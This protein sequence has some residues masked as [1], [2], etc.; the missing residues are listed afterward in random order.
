MSDANDRPPQPRPLLL[1]R[2]WVIALLKRIGLSTRAD[3]SFMALVPIVGILTG[4]VSILLT[5]LMTL[6]QGLFWGAEHYGVLDVALNA[7]WRLCVLAPAAG[8]IAIGLITYLARQPVRGTGTGQLIEAVALHGGYVATAKSLLTQLVAVFTVGS[9]GSAGREGPLMVAGA[10]IGSKLGRARGL[11]GN[12]LKL[13]VGCGIASGIAA[14]YNAP[15][16]GALFAMEVV[17]GNFALNTFAPIVIASVLGTLLSREFLFLGRDR[18]YDL[19]PIAQVH[20]QELLLFAV[21]GIFAGFLAVLFISS[22]EWGDIAFERI[23]V[24]PH[25]KP[26]IGFT[27]L[28]L[29]G[30]AF[31]YIYGNGFE[32]VDIAL[33][34]DALARLGLFLLIALPLVKL[35]ATALTM[36]SGGTGGLFTPSLFVGALVG[37]AFGVGAIAVIPSWASGAHVYALVGMGAIAAATTH[38]PLS[39]ILIIYELTGQYSL[40]LPL[41]AACIVSN[42]ISR[43]LKQHGVFTS[44]MA[45]RGV[46]LPHRLEELVLETMTARD[47]VRE[48]PLCLRPTT[49]VPDIFDRFMETRRNHLYVVD[50]AKNF[51]GA[52]AL[53]DLKHVLQQSEQM[54]F[55]LALDVM[56]PD[57]PY[58]ALD[59]R[60]TQVAQTFA[61]YDHERLPVVESRDSRRFAGVISKRDIMSVYTSE[62][63]Q[64]PSLLAKFTNDPGDGGEKTFV[65]LPPRYRVDQVMV[66]DD[67]ADM[68][69]AEL[70]FPANYL[71]HVLELKRT[72][73]QGEVTRHIPDGTSVLRRGD[74]IVV[75]GPIEHLTRLKEI[76][77]EAE[78]ADGN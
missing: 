37:H 70:N 28:G 44:R 59:D 13:L 31:P 53:H 22:M 76:C 47:I 12:H 21:L 15:I 3:R 74:R 7:G 20:N 49:K 52:V 66:G 33:H 48:D 68:S 8:G 38:A 43:S 40:I 16:G 46:N 24:A 18:V 58:V 30:W 64:R 65:E 78:A 29:V 5:E 50:R 69:L 32:T 39:A 42:L 71:T 19:Q 61:E 23:K 62:V 9:G 1:R 73:S 26:V 14:A 72:N 55:M 6:M 57:F 2:S 67:F 60:L 54:G 34:P 75:L 45:R 36:G 63:L 27:L 4:V 25:W 51:I 77:R 56:L 10:T 35:L 11:S 17:L 41:M